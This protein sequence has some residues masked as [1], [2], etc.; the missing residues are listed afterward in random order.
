MIKTALTIFLATITLSANAA[1]FQS[2]FNGKDLSGWK[3][4]EGFWRV[5]NGTIIGETTKDKPTKGNTFLIWQGGEVQDFEF[6][7]KVKFAGNNSGVQY[8]SEAVGDVNDC[9]LR[10]YQADLHPKQEYFGM[11]YGEKF[12]KR[13]IIAKRG[14][15]VN[16]KGD[17]DIEVLGK[18][19]DGA[20]LKGD[21][22]NTL[23]IVVVG[24]RL[25][26]LVNN[27][28]TVD[29]TEN[30]PGA[31]AKGYLG[32]QLHAGAPMKVECKD[33]QYRKL[34]GDDAAKTLEA[35]AKLQGEH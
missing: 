22:W 11:L 32:L 10:G 26:H 1:D 2:L 31:I 6:S 20:E 25:I 5:E 21:E 30:H 23:R 29:I 13:G 28:V 24:N 35:A 15:K 19:G 7:C 12:G 3:G 16:A 34:A 27:V 14:Q 9:V 4:K 17:K 18:V 33:I 8:R